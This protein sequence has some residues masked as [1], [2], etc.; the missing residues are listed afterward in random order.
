MYGRGKW[1]DCLILWEE[2]LL[3]HARAAIIDFAWMVFMYFGYNVRWAL[4]GWGLYYWFQIGRLKKMQHRWWKIALMAYILWYPVMN[5]LVVDGAAPRWASYPYMEGRDILADLLPLFFYTLCIERGKQALI[6]MALPRRMADEKRRRRA[7]LGV[8]MQWWDTPVAIA[9]VFLCGFVLYA[10]HVL[11]VRHA[12]YNLFLLPFYVGFVTL[13]ASVWK[14][15]CMPFV[16]R[17]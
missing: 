10:L 17:A 14:P 12:V 15:R 2:M 11:F 4:P 8:A 7:F 16:A 5:G 9:L 3:L 13:V 1:V 6:W